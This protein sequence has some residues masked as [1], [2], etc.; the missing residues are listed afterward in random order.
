[1]NDTLYPPQ[2]LNAQLPVAIQGPATPLNNAAL[3]YLNGLTSPA[4][5]RSMRSNLDAVA[6]FLGAADLESCCWGELRKAHVDAILHQL[7]TR[8]SLPGSGKRGAHRVEGKGLAPRTVATY[9]AALKQVA[10]QAW[11]LGQL[12]V[13]AYQHIRHIRPPRG[14]RLP[15]PLLPPEEFAQLLESCLA[16]RSAA[17]IRDAALLG[18]LIGVGLRRSEL[19]SLNLE[20]I[21]LASGRFRITGKGNK[22]RAAHLPPRSI[23]LLQRWV[24][25]VR[26]EQPGPLFVR[27]RKSEDTTEQRLTVAGVRHILDSRCD[28]AGLAR[29]SAHEFRTAFATWLLKEGTPLAT[30]QQA[31]GHADIRTTELYLRRVQADAVEV[32]AQRIHF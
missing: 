17:G 8:G 24:E 4:S 19:G 7:A 23:E 20:Q 6:R 10:Q 18:V 30:I 1:M 9:L 22:E 2:S 13:E 29:R 21:D 28:R 14:S 27:I 16:D 12:E 25:T 15:R 32:T 3:A 11:Q 26:G 31:L 5:R